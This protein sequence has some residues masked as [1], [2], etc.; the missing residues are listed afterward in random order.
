MGPS[1]PSSSP[2]T[3]NEISRSGNKLCVILCL[4]TFCHGWI[5]KIS[6]AL[7]LCMHSSVLCPTSPWNS[8]N[9]LLFLFSIRVII[10]G[11][12]LNLPLSKARISLGDF[13]RRVIRL[14]PCWFRKSLFLS[15]FCFLLCLCCFHTRS[16]FFRAW[17][18]AATSPRRNAV[19][20]LIISST[21][22]GTLSC[23]CLMSLG[24]VIPCMNTD[25]LMH[26]RT[27]LTCLLSALNLC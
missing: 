4:A 17:L 27:P 9:L 7:S 20:T 5:I 11:G 6:L 15:K 12:A 2:R 14:D 25:I 13:V 1:V 19:V 16:A 22:F 18:E 23:K 10:G 8:Q 24:L 3:E 26:F 21:D